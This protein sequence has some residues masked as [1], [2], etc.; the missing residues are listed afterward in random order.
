M[1]ELN[2]IFSI[3]VNIPFIVFCFVWSIVQKYSLECS[4][5]IQFGVQS[6][7]IVWSIV[8][9]YSME[10]SPEIQFGVQSRN[11][12]WSVVQ[13]S[14]LE[15]SPEIQFGVQSRNPSLEC[16]PEIQEVGTL[17]VM[18]AYNLLISKQTAI[19]HRLSRFSQLTTFHVKRRKSR[20]LKKFFIGRQ[21]H[22]LFSIFLPFFLV[23]FFNI[24]C[25]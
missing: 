16:S 15:Y 6:R 19:H 9:K 3:F 2:K 12:V 1:R 24:S 25:I 20:L 23:N 13:K 4:P 10:Y 18:Q 14:S 17:L 8:Q 21:I 22:N 7:N 11:I 5:E